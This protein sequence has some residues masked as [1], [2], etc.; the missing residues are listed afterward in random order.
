MLIHVSCFVLGWLPWL[1]RT[2]AKQQMLPCC[3]NRHKYTKGLNHGKKESFHHKAAHCVLC[4]FWSRLLAAQ[5]VDHYC[6]YNSLIIQTSSLKVWKSFLLCINLALLVLSC[7]Q[8]ATDWQPTI[9]WLSEDVT[10]SHSSG[11]INYLFM[12]LGGMVQA[13][14]GQCWKCMHCICIC[15]RESEKDKVSWHL[16]GPGMH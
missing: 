11:H 6:I 10:L 7:T 9:L 15:E 3:K 1:S 8:G 5:Q 13:K 14:L 4:F 2:F 12:E 16:E